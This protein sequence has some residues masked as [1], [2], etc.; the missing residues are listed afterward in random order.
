MAGTELVLGHFF[1]ESAV[2]FN[3]DGCSLGRS[4]S[5]ELG[6]MPFFFNCFFGCIPGTW[7]P[8]YLGR[9]LNYLIQKNVYWE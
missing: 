9:D 3:H 1:C 7:V 5:T 6:K 4:S 8:T 2:S